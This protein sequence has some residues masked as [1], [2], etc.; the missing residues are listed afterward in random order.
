VN[1][2]VHS[3]GEQSIFQFLDED[4]FDPVEAPIWAM[5]AD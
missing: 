5:D 4:A 2:K 3:S 1:G